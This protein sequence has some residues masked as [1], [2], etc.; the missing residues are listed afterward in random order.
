MSEMMFVM[1]Q[2]LHSEHKNHPGSTYRVLQ[3]TYYTVDVTVGHVANLLCVAVAYL[4]ARRG[5]V[6][7]KRSVSG[8]L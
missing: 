1:C 7:L 2:E 3:K 5:F 4:A 8:V 6:N